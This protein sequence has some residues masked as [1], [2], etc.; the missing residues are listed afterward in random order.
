MYTSSIISKY[1]D[2]DNVKRDAGTMKEIVSRQG[3]SFLIDSL[4]EFTGNNANLF[5]LDDS[6]RNRL[7]L[8]LAK[9]LESSLRERL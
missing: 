8:S 5:K 9:E 6:E 7:I 3:A 1:G 2:T 4:A